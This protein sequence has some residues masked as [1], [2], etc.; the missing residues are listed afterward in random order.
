MFYTQ[1]VI[2]SASQHDFD[3]MVRLFQSQTLYVQIIL[4]YFTIYT[5][6]EARGFTE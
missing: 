6:T 2:K 4:I 3:S 1:I 5:I